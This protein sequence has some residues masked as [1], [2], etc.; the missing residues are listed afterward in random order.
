MDKSIIYKNASSIALQVAGMGQSDHHGRKH[1][2]TVPGSLLGNAKTKKSSGDSFEIDEFQLEWNGITASSLI[3]SYNGIDAVRVQTKVSN[4]SENTHA[5]EHL[6]TCFL[7]NIN[8]EAERGNGFVWLPHNTWCGEAQW[9]RHSIKELGYTPVNPGFSLKRIAIGGAG[10]WPAC[11]YLPMGAYETDEGCVLWQIETSSAWNWEISDLDG[12]LYLSVFGPDYDTNGFVK[13]L[14]PGDVFESVPCAFAF[15]KSFQ[16]CVRQMTLYRRALINDSAKRGRGKVFFNDYMNCLMGD[17]TEEN[18]I[19]L[20]DVA[21]KTGCDYFIIDAGW[22]ADGEWWDGVGEWLPSSA[23]FPSGIAHTLAKIREAGLIPGLWL[24][25]EVMG[26]NCPLAANLPDDW[27]FQRFGH[28]AIDHGRY[29][30]DFRNQ[31]VRAFAD[32]VVDRLVDEYGAGYIKIDFNINIGQ[33]TD[34]NADSA[35]LGLLEH[36]RAYHEWLKE[37]QARH[38]DLVIENCGSGGMRMEY[39]MLDICALQSV[40]DQEDY[41]KTS[42]I[43][44]NCA[45]AALPE[46]T[47]IWSYPKAGAG[48][49][50]IILN[51]VNAILLRIHQSGRI[52]QLDEAGVALVS[53]G[54]ALHKEIAP[55]LE[56]GLPFWPMGLA[57]MDSE[58][59]CFGMSCENAMYIAVWRFGPTSDVVIELPERGSTVKVIYPRKESSEPYFS[60]SGTQVVIRMESKTARLLKVDSVR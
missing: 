41:L 38:P 28:R 25:I 4:G 14:L 46:Q 54:I 45:T 5:I 9:Q 39:A 11:E 22:Y 34:F 23:R 20:I 58:T 32:N 43:A 33:G 56:K 53:E 29:Q 24:E 12:E 50:D 15:G 31:D 51:M 27:F 49:E 36:T 3:Q 21:A 30:L 37:V 8:G 57:T 52:D 7:R 60:D 18:E 6:G 47:A 10:G 35:A 16:D 40:S 26:I 55:E 1:T 44:A 42:I 13:K 19:P 59:A 17:P 2:G 48:R